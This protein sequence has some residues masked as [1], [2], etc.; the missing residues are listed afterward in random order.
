MWVVLNAI[1]E[2]FD[3]ILAPFSRMEPAIGLLVVSVVTGIVMLLIFGKTSNQKAITATKD[4][5]KA[6]IMEMWIFRND[7][8]VMF[9]AIGNVIRNNIQ[10]LRHSLRPIVFIIVPVLIIMVQLGIRYGFE[11][12]EPGEE[13]VVRVEFAEGVTPS[14]MDL[15]L[16]APPGVRVTSPALRLDGERAV[17]WRFLAK[18]TGTHE[19]SLDTPGGTVHKSVVVGPERRI[20]PLSELRPLANTWDAFLYPA[21]PPLPRDGMVRA[22]HV[23]YPSRHDTLFGLGVHWLLIFFVVSLVAGFALKGVFGIDV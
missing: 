19:L 20:E 8:R 3:V 11:P 17:E 10:Y 13:G 15:E 4:K 1:T 18:L 9:G 16:T 14:E 12:F 5:L 23:S 6:Y 22:I 21:E 7:T 2:A